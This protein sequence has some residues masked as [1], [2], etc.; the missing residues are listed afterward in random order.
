[1]IPEIGTQRAPDTARLAA[2]RSEIKRYGVVLG[3][4]KIGVADIALEDDE[5]HLRRWLARRFDGEMAYMSRHGSKR[6]HPEQLVPE[7]IRVVSARMNHLAAD[8][9][10]AAE[11]L[12]NRELGYVA[13]YALG[14]DYHKVVRTRLSKLAAMI[15]EIA[16]TCGYR[17]F[18]D[19]APVLERAL[20]RNAGLGW[21]GKHSNL[22]DREHGSWFFIGE[23]FTD[24]PL[25]VDPP[26]D[27]EYCGTCTRCLEV[28]PTGAIVA[29]YSVDA[30]RCISYLTI[31]LKGSIP[32]EYRPLIGS[33]IFGCDDC[34]LVCPWNRYAR[35][36]AEPDFRVRHGL[37]ASSLLQLFAWTE[38]DFLRYTE[39]SAIRRISYAQWLRN[40]AVA[41]GNA[42]GCSQS[43]AALSRRLE[44]PSELVRE[45]VRWALERHGSARAE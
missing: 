7:T 17:V 31:E 11:V 9:L 25:P 35:L 1:M 33:R 15:E 12:S 24:L 18:C 39:G 26:Y 8:G 21:I 6:S 43:T 22:I 38:A 10:D 13:R 32:L 41:L 16:G 36:S 42:P 28:C 19:S 37:D 30:R 23:I 4:L 45:H 40:L 27:N 3:F 5:H 34:Q 20:A 29:P 44:H 14:R 2:I